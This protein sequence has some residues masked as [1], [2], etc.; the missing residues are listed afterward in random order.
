MR[1]LRLANPERAL[2]KYLETQGFQQMPDL[3]QL[4]CVVACYDQFPHLRIRIC[5]S[6]PAFSSKFQPA[7]NAD[8]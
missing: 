8:F 6:L 1:F 4:A 5:L 7:C 3:S 2:G